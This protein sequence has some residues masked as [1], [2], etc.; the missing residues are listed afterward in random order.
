MLEVDVKDLTLVD[1]PIAFSEEM[2]CL[3]SLWQGK[4]TGSDEV[5][6]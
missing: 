6:G 2:E 1:F 4:L 3:N 5:L